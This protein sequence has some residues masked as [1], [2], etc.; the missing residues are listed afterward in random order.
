MNKNLSVKET[1]KAIGISRPT[2]NRLLKAQKISC[3]R[4][5]T[6]KKPRVLF[7]PEHIR[8]F[9]ESCEQTAR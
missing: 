7:A 9:L 6:G 4:V 2:L 3:F 5:G 8:Q 1:C